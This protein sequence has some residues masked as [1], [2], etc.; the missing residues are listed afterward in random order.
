M[1]IDLEDLR[2]ALEKEKEKIAEVEK[3]LKEKSQIILNQEEDSL[4]LQK[5]I[6]HF[7]VREE[8][9]HG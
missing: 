8:E 4:K 6:D 5:E 2:W 7:K 1:E 3:K 9:Y